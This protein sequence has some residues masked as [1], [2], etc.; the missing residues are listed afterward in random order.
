MMHL[1]THELSHA[2]CNSDQ[3]GLLVRLDHDTWEFRPSTPPEGEDFVVAMLAGATGERVMQLGIDG[4]MH[5]LAMDPAGFFASPCASDEDRTLPSYDPNTCARLVRDHQLIERLA[6]ALGELG[7]DR[8]KAFARS[9]E[10]VAI[11]DGLRLEG[12]PPLPPIRT[13][14]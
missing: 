3:G 9:M 6:H 11:G 10:G 8:I 14:H 12:L 4:A 13:V 1:A 2:L 7:A 5:M